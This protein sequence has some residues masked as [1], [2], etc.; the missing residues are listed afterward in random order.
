MVHLI[1]NLAEFKRELTT[2]RTIA[3]LEA[4]RARDAA[5][6]RPTVWTAQRA[7]AA[8]DLLAAGATIAQVAKALNV[9]RATIY[10]HAN[11]PSTT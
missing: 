9:S 10:R 5:L 7:D 2:E 6:G 8:A 1:A 4:A 11:P 3:G